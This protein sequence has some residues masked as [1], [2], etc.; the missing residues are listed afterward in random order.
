MKILVKGAWGGGGGGGEGM[1]GGGGQGHVVTCDR[2]QLLET[3]K[4]K[5]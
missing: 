4:V 2:M 1:W 3:Y 5:K